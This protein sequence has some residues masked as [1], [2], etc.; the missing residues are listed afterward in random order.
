[1]L[2]V[3]QARCITSQ[4]HAHSAHSAAYRLPWRGSGAQ[5]LRVSSITVLAHAACLCSLLPHASTPHSPTPSP[6]PRVLPA[7]AAPAG[8]DPPPGALEALRLS[9]T[10]DKQLLAPLPALPQVA[11][12]NE[13]L[14][15][16]RV[17]LGPSC[18]VRLNLRP[19]AAPGASTGEQ[20]GVAGGASTGDQPGGA[21]DAACAAPGTGDGCMGTGIKGAVDA[22]CTWPTL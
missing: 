6:A 14:A 4:H 19:A 11:R 2:Q 9:L 17:C 8:T 22:C 18:A 3:P 10:P 5:G 15:D 1:M 16:L 12:F 20:P 13:A 7:G 21:G